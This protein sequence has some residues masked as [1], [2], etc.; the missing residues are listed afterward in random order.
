LRHCKIPDKKKTDT[1]KMSSF[2]LI[3]GAGVAGG[4]YA[5]RYF[6]EQ[7]TSVNVYIL[8]AAAAAAMSSS[9]A[10]VLPI[11]LTGALP[12]SADLL[13]LGAVGAL[14]YEFA[15]DGGLSSSDLSM[16]GG[17]RMVIGAAAAIGGAM[18]AGMIA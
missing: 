16:D 9:I 11:Q 7:D 13:V 2:N 5:A 8:A 4:L 15:F 18:A 3:Q 17:K 14:G 1:K 10:R 12:F 6:M